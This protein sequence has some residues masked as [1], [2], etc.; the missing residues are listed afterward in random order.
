MFDRHRQPRQCSTITDCG[1]ELSWFC[2]LAVLTVWLLQWGTAD[3]KIKV[4][5]IP[6]GWGGGG[7]A[8]VTND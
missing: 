5:D 7:G 1:E 8:V 6:L 3:T 2:Q 4:L